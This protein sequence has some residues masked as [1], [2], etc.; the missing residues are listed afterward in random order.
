[1]KREASSRSPEPPDTLASA[2]EIA[3][4]VA[5]GQRSATAV[6]EETFERIDRLNPRLNA[7]IALRRDDALVEARELDARVLTGSGVGPLAGVPFTVKDVLSTAGLPTTCGSLAVTGRRTDSDAT[8]VARMRRA[9]AILIGKSNCSEFAL[10]IDTDNKRYGKTHNPRGDFT[11]GGSSGGEAVALAV[12]FSA[13]G[14]GTDFGGSARWPAQCTG[15]VGLRPTVGRV[16][17]T[18]QLP[19]LG[20]VGPWPPNPRTLQGRLQVIGPM[21]RTVDDVEEILRVLAGPDGFDSAAAPVPLGKSSDIQLNGIECRWSATIGDS[22]ATNEVAE[23]I[24]NAAALLQR[25]FASMA[26]GLPDALSYAHQV[27]SQL[28]AGEPL[29]EIRALVDDD[30]KELTE[31]MREVLARSGLGEEMKLTELWAERDRLRHDLLTWLHGDRLL[32]LPVSV[33]APFATAPL[34]PT[35][36]P[37][38][39]ADIVAP[40]RLISLFGIPSVSVPCGQTAAGAPLSVQLVAPPFR[41]DLLLAAAKALVD[42]AAL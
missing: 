19:G 1:M 14:L 3:R 26:A 38:A 15:V 8:A 2:V 35:G 22:T 27:Y 32:L 28:R 39:E 11:S 25:R 12:G 34:S 17:A 9:G 6:I 4:K 30:E 41:E 7:L 20:S 24:S 31:R 5:S 29:V 23:A 13:A 21:G 33:V 40:S 10:S 42:D 37:L 36:Q 18:G 16:P